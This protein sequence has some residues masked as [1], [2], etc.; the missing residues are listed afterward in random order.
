MCCCVGKRHEP[1]TCRAKV[2]AKA[3]EVSFVVSFAGKNL[4][5][6]QEEVELN[7]SASQKFTVP[8][9]ITR[10]SSAGSE[11]QVTWFFQKDTKFEQ[12][13][14][15]K[16]DWNSTLPFW[17]G[18]ELRFSRPSPEQFSLTLVTEKSGL[19]FCEVEEWVPSLSHGWMKVAIKRSGNYN[20]SIYTKGK[21]ALIF[22]PV[23]ILVAIMSKR[24]GF[25]CVLS[26]SRRQRRAAVPVQYLSWD[27]HTDHL[28]PAVCHISACAEVVS[29][30][31]GEKATA[32]P[33]D[34]AAPSELQAQCRWL[35]LEEKRGVRSDLVF[36]CKLWKFHM[37]IVL[38]CCNENFVLFL[39]NEY[40]EVQ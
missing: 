11:F 26:F 39:Y 23:S 8:C 18:D 30:Q 29:K 34:R 35:K 7:V 4:S 19:Y 14:I 12:E 40:F 21:H 10:Q 28:A 15:F 33:V 17:N 20:I 31:G 22:F 16:V 13:P 2:A 24:A 37:W 38:I 6:L 9:Q 27:S 25:W 1:T 36:F 5:V 3:N 32:I